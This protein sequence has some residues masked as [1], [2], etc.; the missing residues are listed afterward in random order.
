M[1]KGGQMYTSEL[2]EVKPGILRRPSHLFVY[3]ISENSQGRGQGNWGSGEG[4]A[5]KH[6]ANETSVLY[7]GG[8]KIM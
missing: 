2:R 4:G 8:R 7:I 6:P 3:S 1:I 5:G